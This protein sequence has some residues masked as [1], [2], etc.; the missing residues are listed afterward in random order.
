MIQKELI[1]FSQVVSI[2]YLLYNITMKNRLTEFSK[3]SSKVHLLY[4]ITTENNIF[5]SFF[6]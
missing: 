2:V 4:N 6:F 3:V 5:C 1:E